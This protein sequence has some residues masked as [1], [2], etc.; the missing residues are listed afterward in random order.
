M[1]F[2]NRNISV[3]L[4]CFTPVTLSKRSQKCESSEQVVVEGNGRFGEASQATEK[5]LGRNYR[6]VQ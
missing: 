3:S 2:I 1:K 6:S 5:G 4:E